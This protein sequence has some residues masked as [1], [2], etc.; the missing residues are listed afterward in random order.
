MRLGTGL[1]GLYSRTSTMKFF[2]VDAFTSQV[3]R[4]NSAAVVIERNDIPDAIKQKLAAEFNVSETA[5]PLPLND[6]TFEEADQFS[7]RWF[8]P[9]NEVPLCGHATLATSHVIFNELGNRND[10]IHFQTQSGTLSVAK[11]EGQ[12][13][14]VMPNY[15][16]FN[17]DSVE[18]ALSKEFR[19]M[20][21]LNQIGRQA[22]E[23]IVPLDVIQQLAYNPDSK[24]LVIALRDSVTYEEFIK[25]K[26]QN[27]Q[28]V[29]PEG[30]FCRGVM[31]TFSPKDPQKQGFPMADYVLRYFSPWNGIPE[32]PA[33]GSAQ[34]VAAPF[35][36]KIIG[37]QTL[38]ALQCYPSRGA[39]FEA[40]VHEKRIELRGQAVTVMQGQLRALQ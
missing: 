32:D 34:C 31:I 33:T 12:L 14:M 22:A 2:T 4:G 37:R 15:E 25:Y 1:L 19:Q 17:L 26:P 39:E 23:R 27:I 10:E 8:T 36:A 29:D 13:C 7:L 6:K 30:L 38:K 28:D 20:T 3:F 21:D 11:K 35:W 18:A 40:A 16:A 5:F 24:K 9:T